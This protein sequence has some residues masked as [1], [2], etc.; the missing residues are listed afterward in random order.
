M[1]VFGELYGGAGCV[2][3]MYNAQGKEQGYCVWI[4]WGE[5]YVTKVGSMLVSL[6]TF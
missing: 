3:R 6:I 4:T 5:A 1:L 2:W